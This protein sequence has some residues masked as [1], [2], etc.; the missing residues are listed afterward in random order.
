MNL[1]PRDALMLT[2]GEQNDMLAWLTP[3][4]KGGGENGDN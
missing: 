3:K 2:I 4:E 1:A